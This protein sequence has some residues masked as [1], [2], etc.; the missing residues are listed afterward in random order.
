MAF[1]HSPRIVTDG[2][3]LALDAANSLSYP[4]SGTTW[5]DLSGKGNNG[6]LVNGPTFSPTN[7]GSIVFDGT[8]D[9]IS[10]PNNTNLDSQAITMESWSNPGEVFQNGF[11]FEKGAVNT[12]YSN[13]FNGDGTFY[14]RTMGLSNQDLTFYIPSYISVNTWN[15]IVCTYGSGVKTIYINGSQVAQSTGVTG[16]ISTDTTGLFIGAYGPGT[17]YFLNGKIAESR[18]YNKALTASE[19][20]QNYQALKTRFGL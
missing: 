3:V 6:T 20:Q 15:H 7:G 10:F 11:L 13:F 17:G 19:V 14:F 5:T 12:Q 9:Y 2:L 4:G 1:F 8:N 18:V 16:T